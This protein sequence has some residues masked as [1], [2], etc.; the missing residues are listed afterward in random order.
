ML[1]Q[2]GQRV[3]G[4]RALIEQA[5]IGE[6]EGGAANRRDRA[7]LLHAL[8]KQTAQPG[9]FAGLPAFAAGQDP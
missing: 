9:N 7:L 1:L 2:E 6:G 3:A 8:D 5:G 4:V